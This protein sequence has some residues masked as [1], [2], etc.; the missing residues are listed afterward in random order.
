[1]GVLQGEQARQ[2]MARLRHRGIGEQ[3]SAAAEADRLGEGGEDLAAD[4]FDVS[5]VRQVQDL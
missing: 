4:E 3:R 1:V 5:E 2:A